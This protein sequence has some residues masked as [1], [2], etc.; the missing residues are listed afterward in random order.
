MF[1][2]VLTGADFLYG[3]LLLFFLFVFFS[4]S[5]SNLISSSSLGV[6]NFF[7]QSSVVERSPLDIL[8]RLIFLICNFPVMAAS[9]T[10]YVEAALGR[11]RLTLLLQ[12]AN[13]VNVFTGETY[14]ASIG[15]YGDRVVLVDP[16][17]KPHE[18]EQVMSAEGLT[19]VPGLVDTHLH[20]ESSMMTPWRFA[21][22]VLPHGVTSVFA[23]PHEIANV[24]G[25]AGVKMMIE[26]STGLPLKIK[27]FVPTC[28]P[29]SD[30]VSAGATI[31][32]K[33]VEEM[34]SWN[35]VCGLG[36][37]MDYE[38]VLKGSKRMVEILDIGR[39]TDAV[40]DGHSPLLSGDRLNAY[41][42]AGAEADHENFDVNTAV[43]KL[44]LGMFVKLRGPYLLD[45]RR[46]MSRLKKLPSMENLIFC[47]DDMMPDNLERL[48]HL[49]YIVRSYIEE[50]M[51]PV[52]AVR[53][54]TL[55]PALHMRDRNIGAIAPGRYADIVLLG[56]LAKFEVR[57][58]V[59]NGR[60][61]VKEGRLSSRIRPKPFD[62][63]A[64]RTVLLERLKPSDIKVIAPIKNGTVRVSAIDFSK[65]SGR[66]KD[67]G[68]AF[69]KMALTELGTANLLVR[70]S[71][72]VLNDLALVLVFERHGNGGGRNFG[73]VRNLI[74]KGAIAST[75]A[76]DA[77]NLV[78]VGTNEQDMMLAA[79][80]VIGSQGGI[81]AVQDGATLAHIRLP[82]AG[83][84]SE[85]S[86]PEVAAEMKKLRLAFK[87]MGVLDHPY[88][89]LPALITLS[90]I[91]HARITDKGLFDVD[92]QKFVPVILG[93]K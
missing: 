37:V 38:G 50:G 57:H 82:V 51:D 42:A 30:A 61:V 25:K 86:L 11:R 71:S 39:R 56:N 44:R 21:E 47:T 46:F 74:R 73:F 53:S 84:M 15:I 65:Y 80:L 4:L 40:V 67:P 31:T 35:G 90:V 55:R 33:D 68:E 76:H 62:R 91:P 18:A 17:N 43:E 26:A 2:E 75:I 9:T 63:R 93:A 14:E 49:D 29:E 27:Y 59:A 6:T 58:V 69:L 92:A 60:L 12:K 77:H 89:P 45:A 32:A 10:G 19:A 64:F 72:F 81:A 88:M 7:H 78:V 28:V 16:S 1:T 20:I 5:L 3:P 48:G 8:T 70:N 13:L 41:I 66:W 22:A 54:V 24:L 34:L 87:S 85:Q 36:E 52:E 23:D 83:L 79:N